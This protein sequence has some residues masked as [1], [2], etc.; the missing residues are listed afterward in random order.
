M[1]YTFKEAAN[2]TTLQIPTAA[3]SL[4]K[5]YNNNFTPFYDLYIYSSYR[6]RYDTFKSWPKSPPIPNGKYMIYHVRNTKDILYIVPIW[7]WQCHENILVYVQSTQWNLSIKEVTVKI[8]IN[9]R[10]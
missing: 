10:Y 2:H 4:K 8:C 5:C 9:I 6:R 3:E 1:K 7:T